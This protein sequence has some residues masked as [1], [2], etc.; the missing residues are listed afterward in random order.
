LREE[1]VSLTLTVCDAG[2]GFGGARGIG[3]GMTAMRE[4]AALAG[5]E[6][7]VTSGPGEGTKVQLRIAR[8]VAVG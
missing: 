8:E 6:L 3:V 2:R 1:A 4:R 7:T 5:G